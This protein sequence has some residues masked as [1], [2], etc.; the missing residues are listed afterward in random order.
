MYMSVR[1]VSLLV[2]PIVALSL[3]LA[4]PSLFADSPESARSYSLP[5][6][7]AE[8]VISRWL[9]GTGLDVSRI[10]A[11]DGKFLLKGRKGGESWEIELAPNSPLAFSMRAG[12]SRNGEPCPDGTAALWAFLEGYASGGSPAHRSPEQEAPPAVLA[13][14]GA[15]VCIRAGGGKGTIQF[16]G[17]F[18]GR[19]GLILAT[20]HDLGDA[21]KVSVLLGNGEERAGRLVKIDRARD[22]SLIDIGSTVDASVPLSSGRGGLRAG[23]TVYSVGCPENRPVTVLAGVVD[24]PQRVV[25]D[26]PLWQVNIETMPGG[27][28]SPVFDVPGNLVGVVKGRY[29]GTESRG[30]LIPVGTVLEF[31]GE[32]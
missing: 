30:F 27:S 19:E 5:L 24:G 18:V 32:R 6:A 15:V 7:E 8:A 13:R 4:A 17:F 11:G 20:A 2:L 28:G 10:A 29:R 23:E 9:A 16:S 1:K 22:L 31:L 3:V 14:K 12:C 26:L 25:S 21:R